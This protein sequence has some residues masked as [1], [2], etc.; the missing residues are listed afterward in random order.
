MK[1]LYDKNSKVRTFLVGDKV[2]LF[3]PIPGSPL[4]S[5][6]CGPYE[7]SQVLNSLNYVVKTPDRRKSTRIAHVNQ[8]KLYVERDPEKSFPV[9]IVNSVPEQ[10]LQESGEAGETEEVDIPSPSGNPKNS[11][12][13]EDLD[14][15]LLH[16]TNQQKQDIKVVLS[17]FSK[18]ASDSPGFCSI[19]LHDVVLKDP[20][21]NPIK[22]P[23]YRLSPQKKQIMDKEIDYLLEKNLIEPS[24]SPWASPSILVPKADGSSRLCTDYRKV[25][26]VTVP[27]AYPLPRIDDL[28]DN[29]G[30]AKYVSTIDL[31]K[32]YYQVGL[33]ERAKLISA[34]T[35]HRGLFQY[36]VMP[37]GMTNAPATFQ[38][39]I[40]YT[41]QGLGGVESYLDDIVV[42]SDSWNVHLTSLQKLLDRLSSSGFTIN[43]AKS[44][45][46]QGTVSYLGHEVGQG[47]TRPKTANIQA[48]LAYPQPATRKDLL[49]FLGMAGFYRRFCPNFASVTAPLTDLTSNK[50]KFCWDPGCEAAYV[51]LKKLL[52]SY[53]VLRSPDSSLPY[54]LQVDASD[55]GVGAVLLQKDQASD[56]LHPV[57]YFSAKLKKTSKKLQHS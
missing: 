46:G 42:Y 24:F 5:K 2:L 37:F 34:F 39:I 54:H 26:S 25:N 28:I 55:R 36:K 30:H 49:R 7:V 6:Y 51:Q 12:I 45:F 18:V 16:L 19:M 43:L 3:L 22:Q 38:R 52:S 29:V 47:T 8:M 31:Q 13:L 1:T 17:K 20:L 44:Q 41:I 35:T 33:T 56:I 9:L 40:N 57:S 15:Y 50:T 21:M 48:I 11:I 4:K 27:D 53:P 32:G 10:V 23:Y 14:N